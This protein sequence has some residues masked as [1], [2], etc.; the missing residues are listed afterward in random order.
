MLLLYPCSSS[1]GPSWAI[2]ASCFALIAVAVRTIHST[3]LRSVSVSNL[4]NFFDDGLVGA[5]LG[6][7]Q[8]ADVLSNPGDEGELG[9]FAHGVAGGDP[10]KGEQAGVV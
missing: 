4:H 9:A 8:P 6:E 1:L 7:L 3:A 10:H 2:R 5:D